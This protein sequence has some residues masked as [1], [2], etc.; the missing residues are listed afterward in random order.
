MQIHI[1]QFTLC[2]LVGVLSV[3]AGCN[4]ITGTGDELSSTEI[5]IRNQDDTDHTVLIEIGRRPIAYSAGRTM[6]NNSTAVLEPF[7]E[8]GDYDIR[9]TV[10]NTT[11]A[12]TSS[13]GLENNMTI[14]IYNG[15]PYIVA[16]S[17]SS[18]TKHE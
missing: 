3:S 1:R 6:E 13:F 15:V 18:G 8:S 16:N 14:S 5:T 12:T 11:I 17:S 4:A 10:D 7:N 2:L 9:M